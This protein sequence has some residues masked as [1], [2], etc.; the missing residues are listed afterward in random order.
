MLLPTGYRLAG[1]AVNL[2]AGFGGVV[3]KYG[4]RGGPKTHGQSD[5]WRA[6][7]SVGATSSQAKVLKGTRMA[8]HYGMDRHTVQNLTVVRIDPERNL[9]AI[10]GAVPGPK[11]GW[12]MIRDAVKKALPAEASLPAAIRSNGDA[13]AEAKQEGDA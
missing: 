13:S 11:G 1:R 12:V 3:K 4:F 6:P 2:F 5:R 9:L 8:G 10:K 7:G